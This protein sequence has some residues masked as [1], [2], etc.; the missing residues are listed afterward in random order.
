MYFW[1]EIALLNSR[2]VLIVLCG[3]LALP[4]LAPVAA[5]AQSEDASE[6]IVARAINRP[7]VSLDKAAEQALARRPVASAPREVVNYRGEGKPNF[8][9]D[10]DVPDALLQQ[11]Q[12]SVSIP[13]GSGF[14]G[15]SNN[16]NGA[17]LGFLVAP[18]DTDGQ[19]GPN[20][21]V[22]MINLLT[23]I[24]DK[25][26]NKMSGPFPSNA[27]WAGIGG[28]CEAY[29]Q[30][31][32]VVL[33]DDQEDLWL[34]SQFAFPG[35][36]RTFSQCV[37]ISQTGDP[38]G[39]W[40][41]YEFPFKDI[42]FNDYPKHGITS[43]SITMMANLFKP[44]GPFFNWAGTFLGVMD[45]A[46]MYDGLPATLIGFNIGKNE[47]GFV[48]GDLDGPGSAPALFG[49]AMSNG[50]MFDI[51]EIDVNWVSESASVSRV[52]QIPIAPFDADLCSASR[53]V[54]IPQ[55]YPG[56]KLEAISD[57]LMHR[58]QLRDFGGYRTMVTAHTVDVGGGRA[59]IRWYEMRESGGIW[60]LYQQGTFGPSDGEFR[61]MPS[62][63]MNSAGDIGIG[64][65][66]ASTN[67]Y[68]STA[69]AGQTASG[70]GSGILDATEVIC[71]AGS[72]VQTGV[73]RSGD[74]SSTSVDPMDDTFWHTNEVF[75]T[76]GNFRWDTFVCEFA[77]GG[78]GNSSPNASFSYACTGLSC[79]FDGSGSTG[80]DGSI[81]SYS[82]T[83]GDG[84]TAGGATSN[85]D[86]AADGSYNVTLTVVDN[87]GGSGSQSKTVIVSTGPGNV[88]PTASFTID[89][90]D[91]SCDFDGS[92][93]TDSDGTISNYSWDFGDDSGDS[94]V[95]ATHSY[96]N[97]DDY[98]VT[99]TV[100]DNDGAI[101][102]D[103]QT[104]TATS[105]GGSNL[106]GSAI[107]NGRRWT[108]V[109]T[110]ESGN[111]LDGSWDTNGTDSCLANQCTLAEIPKKVGSVVFTARPG[112]ETV[113]VQKP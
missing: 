62:V 92:G 111:S 35:S 54:C 89:C 1:G 33:Y 27:L 102:A 9:N 25:S 58:L 15:A 53:E 38:L 79:G 20:H 6:K 96:A 16:D 37:A 109:V 8:D 7:L 61:W 3:L 40:N 100:T 68:V 85:H 46:A 30:G 90:T 75:V 29:N 108:A 43:G 21:Y 81:V 110:D 84:G 39:G 42:G 93:S 87:D 23:T 91:L 10:L 71:A 57:R 5:M 24:F 105:A 48:A 44:R 63:A 74:Y 26:G 94:G 101:G 88:A 67:T 104:A 73:S 65:L 28:N 13:I 56:P 80:N 78:G 2:K 41:R 66:L 47:F 45:K 19:V 70:S 11:S 18:P 17:I 59:G 107:N 106:V 113:T 52:A 4:I 82:W 12:G 72:A 31:D 14:P 103:T 76:G 69:V 99:L 98:D 77:V 86:Y 97:A 51:W 83:F 112:G 49:T 22:Q 36:L 95:T 34:V 55:P 60:A 50:G 64:Y 32:P